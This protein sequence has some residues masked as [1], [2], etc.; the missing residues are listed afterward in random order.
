MLSSVFGPC[1]AI[2]AC[3][4]NGERERMKESMAVFIAFLPFEAILILTPSYEQ[5]GGLY[6]NQVH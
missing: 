2:K 4:R 6:G 1:W 5:M 3:G